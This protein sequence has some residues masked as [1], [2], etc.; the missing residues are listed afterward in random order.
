V[1]SHDAFDHIAE[2][3]VCHTV[4]LR[5]LSAAGRQ[6][7]SAAIAAAIR[8][9]HMALPNNNSWSAQCWISA[10][11]KDLVVH[12]LA[13]RRGI[14]TA[15]L[16]R[17]FWEFRR[18]GVKHVD[19]NVQVN[20]PMGTVGWE[21]EK[22]ARRVM[23]SPEPRRLDASEQPRARTANLI[24]F[25]SLKSRLV[26][27]KSQSIQRTTRLRP[28]KTAPL[29]R[30]LACEKIVV[31]QGFWSGRRAPNRDFPMR[32]VPILRGFLKR[33]E[34]LCGPQCEPKTLPGDGYR[35][36]GKFTVLELL[37]RMRTH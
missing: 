36:C 3:R 8:A 1:R 25:Y 24:L 31:P 12:P 37:L 7:D 11:I 33:Q 5:N 19:E 14:A 18:R 23:I 15:L 17:V 22:P 28:S 2:W 9:L 26:P 10:F 21:C 20:N 13:R 30:E 27:E 34:K 4:K 29:V 6:N 35:A 16:S 32:E